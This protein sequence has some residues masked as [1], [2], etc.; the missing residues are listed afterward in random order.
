MVK[1]LQ[2]YGPYNEIHADQCFSDKIL[3]FLFPEKIR[4]HYS[5]TECLKSMRH[6][7]RVDR[8]HILWMCKQ[9]LV[10]DGYICLKVDFCFKRHM[11]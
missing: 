6:I 1:Y 11:Q 7:S 4:L 3:F 9:I 5:L 2:S 10:Y 8:D